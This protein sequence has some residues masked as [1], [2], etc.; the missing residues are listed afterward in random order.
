M[1]IKSLHVCGYRSIR[2]F[3]VRLGPVNVLVGANGCGKSNLYQAMHLLAAAA[4]GQ[5][6]QALADEG[7]LTSVLWAGPRRKRSKTDPVR[8][9]LAIQLDKA[10]FSLECGLPPDGLQRAARHSQIWVTTHSMA[11]TEEIALVTGT[12]TLQLDKVKGETRIVGQKVAR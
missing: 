12:P 9:R 11:L 4:H 8:L 10:K 7:G 2:D 3:D 5:F 1:A 6:A